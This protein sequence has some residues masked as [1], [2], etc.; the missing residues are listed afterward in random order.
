MLKIIELLYLPLVIYAK[1]SKPEPQ[2]DIC[3]PKF[4]AALFTVAKG[5]KQTQVSI[6]G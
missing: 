5:W 6:H 4:I 2:T 1:Q 3:T